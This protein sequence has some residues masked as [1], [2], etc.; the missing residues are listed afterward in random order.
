VHVRRF[1]IPDGYGRRLSSDVVPF[2][3]ALPA[4]NR[5]FFSFLGCPLPSPIGTA[6]DPEKIRQKIRACRKAGRRRLDA[7]SMPMNDSAVMFRFRLHAEIR[8][9]LSGIPYSAG[10]GRTV[11]AL[12]ERH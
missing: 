7:S 3:P 10:I 2:F 6:P 4:S 9:T 12:C 5:Q 11:P 1:P 8:S